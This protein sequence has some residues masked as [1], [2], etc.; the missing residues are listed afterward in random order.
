MSPLPVYFFSECMH[1]LEREKTA[2]NCRYVV[3]LIGFER[4]QRLRFGFATFGVN[5]AVHGCVSR[6]TLGQWA[7]PPVDL[8]NEWMLGSLPEQ[9]TVWRERNLF[10]ND[11]RMVRS[12]AEAQ[13]RC[14]LACLAETG[15]TL[16]SH[17]PS[18]IL[19]YTHIHT[20]TR[21][22]LFLLIP[23]SLVYTCLPNSYL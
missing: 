4:G 17:L 9:R 6:S 19:G 8:S 18:S 14:R 20:Y 1:I 12:G 2:R 7:S 15:S 10:I 21:I 22:S 23:K 3:W 11:R 5:G 13:S 16:C